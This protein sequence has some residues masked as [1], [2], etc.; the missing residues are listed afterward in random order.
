MPNYNIDKIYMNIANEI[1]KMSY[2]KRLQVGA[3]IVKD[4]SIIAYGYNGMPTGFDN[5]CEFNNITNPEVLHAESNAIAKI[6]KSNISS[7]NAS[8][9]VTTS[10]C[11]ECSKLLIQSGIKNVYFYNLYR[12]IDGLKL[13]LKANVNVFQYMENNTNFF[14]IYKIK[15]ES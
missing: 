8:V 14:E 4:N 6:A 11:L 5:S 7:D 15:N 9:Y 3:I 1:S 13:L 2:A 12:N 10:P